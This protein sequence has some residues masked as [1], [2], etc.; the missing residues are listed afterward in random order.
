MEKVSVVVPVY[1]IDRE[2]LKKCIESILTQSYKNIE[3]LLINDGST[4]G[5]EAECE[6]AAKLDERVIYIDQVNQGVS[7]A[8]NS[9][10]DKA[11]G[12][13]VMFVDGDDYLSD[14]TIST[15]V[16]HMRKNKE[17]QLLFF[18][19]CTNYTNRE[20]LRVMKNFDQ[21]LFEKNRLQLAIL[22]GDPSLGMVELGAPWGKLIRRS[23]IEDNNVRYTV[24][25][26]KG[27]DTV[28]TLHLL[29]YCNNISYLPIAGYHY[30]MSTASISHRYNPEII[31]I[32]EKTLG[33]YRDFAQKYNKDDRYVNA[34]D[35]K[36]YKALMNEY[37][38]LYFINGKNPNSS[39]VNQAEFKKLIGN[40]YYS[41]IIANTDSRKLSM[42]GKIELLFVKKEFLGMLWL[43]KKLLMFAK[44][45]IVR[46]YN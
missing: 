29:E 24:G 40:E 17:L 35:L 10:L 31:E 28:F 37:L 26:R 45:M 5:C 3:L 44:N 21:S 39:K 41:K 25:L 12:E 33:A 36:S 1:N 18:G 2:Y 22:Q 8:R 20:M 32:M 34:V 6:A 19:Y 16:E 46:N 23:V 15:V 13:Y 27:Q 7:V 14:G 43:E 4:N 38:D 42:I 30:R 11:S 9:G